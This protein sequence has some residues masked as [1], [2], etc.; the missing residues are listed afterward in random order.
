M[1]RVEDADSDEP[2]LSSGG[3]PSDR[4][5]DEGRFVPGTLLAGRYRIVSL[6]GRGGMGEVYRADD[7]RLRQPVALKLLSSRLAGDPDRL[8]R[9]H[10][11]VRLARLVSHPNVCR[12]HDIGEAD[13]MTFLTMEYVD[14]ENL[15]SLL[16][17]V[18]RLPTDRAAVVGR[19]ICAGLAAAHERG[20]LHRDLKPANVM[21]DGSGRARLT[22]FGLAVAT[23]DAASRAGSA[24]TPAYMALEQLE[25]RPVSEKTDLYALG[26]VL[27]ELFTGRRAFV[28]DSLPQL[29]GLRQSSSPPTPTTHVPDLEPRIERVIVQCLEREPERRPAS[30]TAVAAALLGGDA[31]AAAVAAGETPSPEMVAAAGE[32]T[33]LRTGTAIALVTLSAA[34]QLLGVWLTRSAMLLD[35]IPLDKPPQA[36]A[37]RAREILGR[38]GHA[39]RPA[40]RA[41][42]FTYDR[43]LLHWIED[44]DPSPERWRRLSRGRPAIVQFWYRESKRPMEPRNKRLSVTPSDPPLEAGMALLRLD[45]QGRLLELTVPAERP[46]SASPSEAPRWDALLAEAGLDPGELRPAP[47]PWLPPVFADSVAAFAGELPQEPAIP[48][49]VELASHAG[50]AVAFRLSGPWDNPRQRVALP[51]G[52]AGVGAFTAMLVPVLLLALLLGR[53][54]IRLGR[55]DR[56]GAFRIALF[57]FVCDLLYAVLRYGYAQSA[58]DEWFL[59]ADATGTALFDAGTVWVLYVALEPFVRRRWPEALVSWTRVLSG[60]LAD[61]FVGH[62]ILVAA[63]ASA[64]S[65]L[66]FALAQQA[67]GWRGRPAAPTLFAGYLDFLL[68]PTRQ[69]AWLAGFV[70]VTSIVM[71]LTVVLLFVLLKALVRS[72]PAAAGALWI[73]YTSALAVAA[74]PS[75]EQLL[76]YG[77]MG[78]VVTWLVVRHGL[79]A[80]ALSYLFGALLLEPLATRHLRAWY[81]EPAVLSYALAAG[82]LGWGLYATLAGRPF[83]LGQ[84]LVSSLE[85]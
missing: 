78:A 2:T 39:E 55:S 15:A 19:Q 54:N 32:R 23:R 77:C 64:A 12:V 50:Q 31:L 33:G 61:P 51:L 45:T 79:L 83:H 66:F 57:T 82:L 43:R 48:L 76:F 80:L 34:A 1:G 29:I 60:R 46:P 56:R 22:D 35:R 9:L 85:E 13:G 81:G 26:L 73:L 52:R 18:G 8:A 11:E 75:P 71:A 36:L 53:R 38:L 6:A 5:L 10:D 65:V 21:I 67:P 27:Y 37:E 24:G 4:P 63:A 20:V 30:A 42:G 69:L 14:G 16:R 68:G 17:R 58:L 47:Q 49:R 7:L 3:L 40:D 28:A 25:G 62:D 74:R 59:F 72:R 41:F 84:R 44:H 70:A